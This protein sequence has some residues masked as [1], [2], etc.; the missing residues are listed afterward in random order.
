MVDETLWFW[1]KDGGRFYP[2]NRYSNHHGI[3]SFW[4]SEGSNLIEDAIPVASIAELV[5]Q[6]FRK[7]RSIWLF[8]GGTPGRGG[9]YR[10]GLR[11]IKSWGGEPSVVR[12]ALQAGAPA[13]R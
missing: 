5:D 13:P 8:D 11:T 12:L 9:L 1:H 10:F 2:W 4:V 7:G 6:V 3:S